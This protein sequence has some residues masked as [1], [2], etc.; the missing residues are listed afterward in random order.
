MRWCSSEST[1]HLIWTKTSQHLKLLHLVPSPRNSI[2]VSVLFQISIYS[3]LYTLH[4]SYIKCISNISPYATIRLGF[5]RASEKDRFYISSFF[6][7]YLKHTLK[8]VKMFHLHVE[9]KSVTTMH[10][11]LWISHT[12]CRVPAQLPLHMQQF[13]WISPHWLSEC[14][15]R[16]RKWQQVF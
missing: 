15:E 4:K 1:G 10:F 2:E 5:S 9:R 3:F 14:G 13:N 6:R 8:P 7:Y 16:A 12:S 11:L